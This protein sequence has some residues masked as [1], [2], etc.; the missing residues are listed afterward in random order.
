MNK[1]NKIGALILHYIKKCMQVGNC[2]LCFFFYYPTRLT[3][4]DAEV[5]HL[6]FV[7]AF[8]ETTKRPICRQESD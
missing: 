5:I 2:L 3:F 4:E 1:I 8:T 7:I 6:G